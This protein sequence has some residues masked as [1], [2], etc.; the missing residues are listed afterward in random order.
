MKGD[1]GV[2]PIRT[3]TS[4]NSFLRRNSIWNSPAPSI[5]ELKLRT[6]AWEEVSLVAMLTLSGQGWS[7]GRRVVLRALSL[8]DGAQNIQRQPARVT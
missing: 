2:A 1:T 7:V 3:T 8:F 5:L 6:F 4:F